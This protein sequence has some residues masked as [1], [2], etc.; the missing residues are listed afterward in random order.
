[1]DDHQIHVDDWHFGYKLNFQEQNTGGQVV[2]W[3]LSAAALH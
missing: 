2:N 1:M 3:I